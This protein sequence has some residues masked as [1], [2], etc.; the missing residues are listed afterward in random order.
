MVNRF[1]VA[2]LTEG[3][4]N[5]R[6][7]GGA[8]RCLAVVVPLADGMHEVVRE[9]LAEGPPFDPAAVGLTHHQVLVTDREAVFLFESDK[10][11]ETLERILADPEFWDVVSAWEHA[12]A[13][14]PRLADELYCWPARKRGT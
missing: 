12:A 3:L 1:D 5:L 10:G 4:A 13:G 7:K 2:A 8:S 14:P 9:Y 11:I 6:A